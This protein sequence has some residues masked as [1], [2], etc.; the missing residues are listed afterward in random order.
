[1][2]NV[3]YVL[4]RVIQTH[5]APIATDGSFTCTCNAGYEGDPMA[6]ADKNE[7]LNPLDNDCTESGKICFN[8]VGSFGCQTPATP[9]AS[10]SVS[11]LPSVSLQPSVSDQPLLSSQPSVSDQLRS[12]ASPRYR[13]NRR[14]PSSLQSRINCTMLV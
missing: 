11:I 6:C 8:T 2:T 4:I 12:P 13:F 1:M 7:C 9:A 5:S 10:P 3:R 14:C